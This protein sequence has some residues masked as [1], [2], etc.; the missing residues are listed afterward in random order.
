LEA[1]RDRLGDALSILITNPIDVGYLRAYARL[2]GLRQ[3][4]DVLEADVEVVEAVQ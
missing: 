3:S 2:Q 4:M 1:E